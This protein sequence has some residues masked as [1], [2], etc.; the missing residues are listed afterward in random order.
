MAESLSAQLPQYEEATLADGLALM[1]AGVVEATLVQDRLLFTPHY[2]GEVVDPHT[3]AYG[4]IYSGAVDDPTAGGVHFADRARLEAH[5]AGQR[6]HVFATD[7][8]AASCE[9]SDA[10]LAARQAQPKPATPDVPIEQVT[11]SEEMTEATKMECVMACSTCPFAG[12]LGNLATKRVEASRPANSVREADVRFVQY[13]GTSRE[14][15]SGTAT[16]VD[17]HDEPL[18]NEMAIETVLRLVKACGA[19][20]TGPFVRRR[21][22]TLL[23]RLACSAFYARPDRNNP[24]LSPY[25]KGVTHAPK[26]S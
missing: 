5:A 24:V 6:V 15:H 12:K 4:A 7:S 22:L 14:R 10:E 9:A 26:S 11:V 8:F 20:N 19:E 16:I 25:V 18:S 21:G 13:S 2:A 23:Q 17:A 3:V 1:D